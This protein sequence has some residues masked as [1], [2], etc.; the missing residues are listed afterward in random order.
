M[1]NEQLKQLPQTLPQNKMLRI[2]K[3]VILSLLVMTSIII[4][5]KKSSLLHEAQQQKQEKIDKVKLDHRPKEIRQQYHTV[6][7]ATMQQLVQSNKGTKNISLENEIHHKWSKN[8]TLII[9]DSI[10][11]G[12]E[13]NRISRQWRKDK[14]KSFP[15]AT[16]EDMY[17]YI[18]PLL[19]KCPK[20]MIL[21]IGTN[22]TVNETSRIVLE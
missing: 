22:N 2:F 6:F 17:D 5:A 15:G 3:I 4:N 20:N 9:G 13:E 14:V 16:T 8:T 19:K 11:S 1:A 12:I 21:H 10:V 7:N 18:E